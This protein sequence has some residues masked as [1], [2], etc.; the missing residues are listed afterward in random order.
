M[1]R[2]LVT[3]KDGQI[4]WELARAL[5]ALPDA[6]IIMAGRDEL[7]L[8]QPDAIRRVIGEARPSIVINAAAYT[9]VDRAEDETPT[10]L[11]IN[12]VAPGI[13]AE[14]TKRIGALLIHY[15]T[16]YVFD[17]IRHEPY[18]EADPPSPINQYGW[19][20]LAGERAVAAAGGRH[21]IL[22]TSWVYGGRGRNFMLTILRM[23]QESHELRIVDDQ[24]GVPN[25]SRSIAK[26]T[27]R[28][29]ERIAE[30]P[31]NDEPSGIFHLSATGETSW[32][33]FARAILDACG[34][35]G[36]QPEAPGAPSENDGAVQITPIASSE[37]PTRARRP[38]YSVLSNRKLAATFGIEIPHWRTHIADAL[39]TIVRP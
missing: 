13:I 33:G 14:E 16:D 38:A 34:T 4:G 9:H 25:W 3:G 5:Q 20:K 6:E 8:G 17:G 28:I 27:V 1:M 15:S 10:A 36:E 31:R 19:S 12:G 29:I 7:D 39:K 24:I 18:S 32:C 26:T 30:L 11:Y 37:Y 22:R 23:A 21:L 2:I 35:P